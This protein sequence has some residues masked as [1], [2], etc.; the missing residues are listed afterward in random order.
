MGKPRRR[1]PVTQSMRKKIFKRQNGL[2]NCGCGEALVKGWIANHDP[3]LELR[4]WDEEVKDTVPPASDLSHIFGLTKE[5]DRT[6]TYGPRAKATY[7]NSDRHAIDKNKR[8]RGEVKGPKL[9]REWASRG[10]GKRPANYTPRPP[11]QI[12]RGE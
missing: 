9:K 10:F 5:C 11:R 6:Q 1:K 12:E 7:L 2:C 8:L 4:V 3:P